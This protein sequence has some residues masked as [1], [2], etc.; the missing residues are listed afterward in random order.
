MTYRS[1][2]T[3]MAEKI[4]EG[5]L[6]GNVSRESFNEKAQEFIQAAKIWL[7][8]LTQHEQL[9]QGELK[10]WRYYCMIMSFTIV[11]Y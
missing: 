6:L 5:T 9:Y 8:K 2:L 11:S 1:K 10:I 3:Y 4:D 7:P